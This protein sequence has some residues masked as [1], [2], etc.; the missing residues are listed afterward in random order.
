ML[1]DGCETPSM[2]VIR[3]GEFVHVPVRQNKSAG[4]PTH[5]TTSRPE[6]PDTDSRKRS[7]INTHISY[8]SRETIN[9][10]GRKSFDFAF[11]KLW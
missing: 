4:N 3:L 8:K 1:T 9:W 5:K 10:N 7:L 2:I 6:I 11:S